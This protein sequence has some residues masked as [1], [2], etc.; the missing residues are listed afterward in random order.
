MQFDRISAPVETARASCW[1][2]EPPDAGTMTPDETEILVGLLAEYTKTREL[3]C[4]CIWDGYGWPHSVRTNEIVSEENQEVVSLKDVVPADVLTGRRVSLP[5]RGYIMYRGPI[6]EVTAF[7][8]DSGLYGQTPNLWWPHDR[9]WCVASEVDLQWT[10]VGGSASLA[11][12]LLADRRLEVVPATIQD[13]VTF[14]SDLLN[15]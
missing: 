4:F 12:R 8:S 7:A 1:E 2:G 14:D 5:K 13:P 3:C 9:E 6:E 11:Y 10:Y 15:S